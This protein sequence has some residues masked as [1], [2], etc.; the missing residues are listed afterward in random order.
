MTCA[1]LRIRRIR[2]RHFLAD[3]AGGF[4]VIAGVAVFALWLALLR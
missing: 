3:L 4:M 2:A 1:P